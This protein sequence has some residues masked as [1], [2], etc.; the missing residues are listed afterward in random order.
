MTRA[1]DTLLARATDAGEVPGV[2]AAVANRDGLIYEG[3]FGVRR[4][5]A[6]IR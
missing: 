1:L 4:L 2:V 6:P 3:G 5:A